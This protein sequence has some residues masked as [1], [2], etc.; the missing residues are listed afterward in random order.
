[1]IKRTRRYIE[2]PEKWQPLFEKARQNFEDAVAEYHRF[3]KE[4]KSA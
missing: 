2:K 1:L 4:A 3:A